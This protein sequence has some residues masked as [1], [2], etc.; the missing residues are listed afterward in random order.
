[1][2]IKNINEQR[3][4]MAAIGQQIMDYVHSMREE[5]LRGETKEEYEQ[6]IYAKA[7]SGQKLTPDEMSFLARTNP[8]MYQKVLRAQIMRKALEKQLQSCSSKQE[9]ENVF[10]AAVS[11]ISEKDPDRDMILAAYT[12]AYKEF[13]E[14]TQ[15]KQLPDTEEE[16]K[17]KRCN[18]N[19]EIQINGQGYQETYLQETEM[20]AFWTEA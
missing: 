17:C 3:E 18:Q 11:S 13:K 14:S 6:R 16:A 2:E 4:M 9:A 12:Q 1:M 8:A 10:S 19:V 5:G 15:Y 7:Q 20:F